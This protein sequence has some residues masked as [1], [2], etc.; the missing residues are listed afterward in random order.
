MIWQMIVAL[1]QSNRQLRTESDGDIEKGCQKPAVQQ[2]SSSGDDDEANSI[3]R[4]KRKKS[5]VSC[6]SVETF[7]DIT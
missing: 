3:T 5:R 6:G 4:I 2:K 7:N 1:L